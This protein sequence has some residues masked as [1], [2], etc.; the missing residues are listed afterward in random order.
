MKRLRVEFIVKHPDAFI[1]RF[2]Q[3]PE[4]IVQ[5]QRAMADLFQNRLEQDHRRVEEGRLHQIHLGTY[6]LR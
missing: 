6:N 1:F 4:T 3:S 2:D 5:W